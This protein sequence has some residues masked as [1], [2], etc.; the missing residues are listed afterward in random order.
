MSNPASE[1]KS[2][3]METRLQRLEFAVRSIED[4]NVRVEID[5]A[6]ETSRFRVISISFVTWL[7][8]SLV[9]WIIGVHRPLV[10]ALIPTIGFYLSTQTLPFLKAWWLR[11]NFPGKKG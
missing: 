7:V 5:K 8:I 9:F 4:R 6:W 1:S 11:R 3:E 2:D 10:N